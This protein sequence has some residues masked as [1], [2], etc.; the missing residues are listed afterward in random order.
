MACKIILKEEY[1]TYKEALVKLN[2]E[3]IWMI[4]G[5]VDL[6]FYGPNML[7]EAENNFVF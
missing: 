3:T 5:F 6:D 1:T 2:L 7:N 4:V